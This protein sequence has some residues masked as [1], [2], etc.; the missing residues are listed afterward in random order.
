MSNEVPEFWG[1]SYI[2]IELTKNIS[3]RH[4]LIWSWVFYVWLR[5]SLTNAGFKWFTFL[6]KDKL[7]LKSETIQGD[8]YNVG[9]CNLHWR[10]DSQKNAHQKVMYSNLNQE[11]NRITWD[12]ASWKIQLTISFFF[13]NC[14]LIVNFS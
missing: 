12:L 7:G 1:N 5:V 4:V 14:N 2:R 13:R 11:S 6:C 9:H 10:L 8:E 3:L